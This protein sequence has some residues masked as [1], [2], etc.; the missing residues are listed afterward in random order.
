MWVYPAIFK[1]FNRQCFKRNFPRNIKDIDFAATY[2][3][4]S[5]LKAIR[6][7]IKL[8]DMGHYYLDIVN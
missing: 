3:K 4:C 1:V 7:C 2:E 8:F 5:R 6:E